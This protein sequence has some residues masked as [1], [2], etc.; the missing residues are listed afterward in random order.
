MTTVQ[1]VLVGLFV[2][3]LLAAYSTPIL[4]AVRGVLPSGVKLPRREPVPEVK[5]SIAVVLVD[6]IL[7]ITELRDR[8]TA[9][10]CSEGVEACTTLLRV[11][12]EY[13][14]PSK[15]VV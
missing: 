10:G 11:I 8:L 4:K 7:A 5:P 2:L 9:E 14:Q 3:S 1:I 6:D 15:G 13:K 12:V